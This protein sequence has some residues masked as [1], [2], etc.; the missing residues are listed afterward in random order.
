ML[1]VR[2]DGVDA[3]TCVA[4]LPAV[5]R[6]IEERDPLAGVSRAD[7][8]DSVFRDS[9]SIR[10]FQ[11][12]LFGGF[13]AAALVVVGVGI[14]GLIAMAAAQLGYRCHIYAPEADSIAAEV[15]AAFTRAAWDDAAAMTLGNDAGVATAMTQLG[16]RHQN[17][18]N[19]REIVVDEAHKLITTP[20]YMFD[21]ASLSDVFVGI[22]RCVA[23]VLKRV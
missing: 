10:R 16:Q 13:A 2:T 18:P 22:E 5:L 20:A 21:D 11:S 1:V 17:T 19:S 3:S 23:E 8:L 9:V 4:G 14:F 6:A 12:W 7:T 15:S